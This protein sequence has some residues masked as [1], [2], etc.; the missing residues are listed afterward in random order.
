M[1]ISEVL[2]L[3]RLAILIPGETVLVTILK[4]FTPIAKATAWLPLL[5]IG[6]GVLGS[7]LWAA[8][9]GAMD[10]PVMQEVAKIVIEGGLAGL[11]ASGLWS[12]VGRPV[13]AAVTKK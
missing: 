7:A 8:A 9:T 5:S 11:S 12:L 13:T 3:E 2:N 6:V 4:G 10:A 1:D